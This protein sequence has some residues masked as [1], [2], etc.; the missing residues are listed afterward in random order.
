M[1]TP[2]SARSFN[3][4]AIAN[5]GPLFILVPT[6]TVH[7]PCNS[8]IL[9][10]PIPRR[11]YSESGWAFDPANQ[12]ISGCIKGLRL[13]S[14]FPDDSP[15]TIGKRL[16]QGVPLSFEFSSLLPF[17]EAIA[18]LALFQ[19]QFQDD[20]VLHYGLFQDLKPQFVRIYPFQ[21]KEQFPVQVARCIHEELQVKLHQRLSMENEN[22]LP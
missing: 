16:A 7:N 3:E 2:S 10:V 15:F 14:P 9:G 22:N 8:S 19:Y 11:V 18:A 5:L 1:T 6:G 17:S 12:H 13:T 4:I 21:T 20:L